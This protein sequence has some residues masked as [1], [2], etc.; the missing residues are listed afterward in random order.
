MISEI[1]YEKLLLINNRQLKYKGIFIASELF[2]AVNKAI[3]EQGYTKREKK[4]EETVTNEGRSTYIELRPFKEITNYLTLMIKIKIRLDG[5]TETTEEVKNEKRVFQQGD[6]LVS[7]DAWLMADYKD[8]WGMKPLFYFLKGMANKY[9]IKGDIEVNAPG[10][11]AQDTAIIYARIKTQLTSYLGAE[12][13]EIKEEEIVK[14]VESE[15]KK[16][17]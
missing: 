3:E 4:S 15:L 5:I 9:L 6:I 7:F 1:N 8:R 16:E 11:L 17:M 14:Q 12:T 13:K 10:Q 2:N